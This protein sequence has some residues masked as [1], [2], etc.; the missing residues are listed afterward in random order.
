MSDPNIPDTATGS[1]ATGL[2][3]LSAYQGLLPYG[4]IALA[5]GYSDPSGNINSYDQIQGQ[6]TNQITPDFQNWLSTS[7]AAAGLQYGPGS[8]GATHQIYGANGQPIAG[9]GWKDYSA[10]GDDPTMLLATLGIGAGAAAGGAFGAG[11]QSAVGGG[12][13]AAEASALPASQVGAMNPGVASDVVP[14]L[15]RSTAQELATTVGEPA[16][17]DV[18]ANAAAS[19]AGGG[20]IGQASALSSPQTD[21]GLYQRAIDALGA[22]KLQTAQLGLGAAG[23]LNNIHQGNVAQKQYQNVAAGSKATSDKLL[24]QFN[25]G[26]LSGADSFAIA[27]WSQK[28][29]ASVDQ[30]YAKAGLSNSSMHQQAMQQID[31]Q[32]EGMRQQA[33]QNMLT[34]GLNAAGVSDPTLR[35]GIS[36]GLQNDQY[37]MKT[38]QDFLSTLAKMNTQQQSQTGSATTPPPGG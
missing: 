32:A 19:D 22:N 7:P 36:A 27:D 6:Y 15:T 29:K 25:S 4:Q 34:G 35:A 9:T 20:S 14:E 1:P 23:L 31:T 17:T 16:G 21:P 2:Q 13:V 26:Q 33:L 5:G 24:A 37:A 10:G 8:D 28:Q 11:A 3:P 18:M 12:P 30:Y 38:M